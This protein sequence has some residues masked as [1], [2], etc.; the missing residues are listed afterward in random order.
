MSKKYDVIIVGGGP[1][2]LTAGLYS[3]RAGLNTILIEQ[4][5]FGGQIVNAQ[6]LENYPGFPDGIAGYEISTLMHQQAVKYGLETATTEVVDIKPGNLF[7][8]LTT[9]DSFQA[10]ALIIATGAQYSKLGVAGEEKYIGRGVS[11]CA[12]CDGFLF[13][14]REVSVVG[15]GDTAIADALE[16][17][18]H[19]AKVY[20]I[21]RRDELRASKVL[22]QR[23]FAQPKMEFV[24]DTVVEEVRGA[25]MVNELGL[26]NVKTGELSSLNIDG[27]FIAVGVKPNSQQFS[28]L[29]DVD[30]AGSIITDIV[31]ST[32]VPGIFAAGD[33]RKNS[34]RQVS[35]AVGDGA[36]AAISAFKYITER[37]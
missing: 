4:A 13:K 32:S 17:A 21:H 35:T 1:A 23:A 12:T 30:E 24:W 26:R 22:Q 31:M 25:E 18:Q 29:V 28:H 2:G 6:S 11:Y 27:V 37:K 16:L 5:L 15:G 10:E 34:S 36:T 20:V 7:E 8:V 3:S 9:D 14:D 19:A 33:V